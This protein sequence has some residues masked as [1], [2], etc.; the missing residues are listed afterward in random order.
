M[1]QNPFPSANKKK[2]EKIPVA[3][4]C[5]G[6]PIAG[7]AKLISKAEL[8]I[9]NA[10]HKNTRP[11]TRCHIGCRARS[12]ALNCQGPSVTNSSPGNMWINVKAV[13]R[14]KMSSRPANCANA[15]FAGAVGGR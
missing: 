2:A 15:G 13:C 7:M 5:T 10:A 8:P 9:V 11:F 4:A 3:V 14:A 6:P 12:P 1:C